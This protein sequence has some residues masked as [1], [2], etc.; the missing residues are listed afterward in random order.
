MTVAIR[1]QLPQH[2]MHMREGGDKETE[3]DT[4]REVV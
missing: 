2:E 1:E 4:E 3:R